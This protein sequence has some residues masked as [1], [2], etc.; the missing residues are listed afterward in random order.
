MWHWRGLDG[1]D[2]GDGEARR[3]RAERRPW[4]GEEHKQVRLYF[5]LAAAAAAEVAELE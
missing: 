5:C 3:A 4:G 2:T 1:L